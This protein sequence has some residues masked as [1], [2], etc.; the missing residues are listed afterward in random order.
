MSEQNTDSTGGAGTT[1]AEPLKNSNGAEFSFRMID[2]QNAA[3]NL[4]H[5]YC[6]NVVI[7]AKYFPW[8]IFPF[9]N[10][11]EQFSRGANVYFLF[12]A[13]LSCFSLLR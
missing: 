7:S 13:V 12:I 11:A 6:S 9:K 4:K 3:Y 10:L 2:L 8:W 5:K 1:E